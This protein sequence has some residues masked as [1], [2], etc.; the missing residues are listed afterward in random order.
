MLGVPMLA[1]HRRGDPEHVMNAALVA[2]AGIGLAGAMDAPTAP[3]L[4]ALERFR[5]APQV[6]A[7]TREMPTASE[8]VAEEVLRAVSARDSRRAP[9]REE[10]LG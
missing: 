8:A 3:L 10:R 2:H 7:R 5:V 6:V 4:A 9:H 1:L